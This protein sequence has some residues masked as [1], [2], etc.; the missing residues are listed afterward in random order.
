M[1]YLSKEVDY[2]IQFMHAVPEKGSG[3]LSLRTFSAQT[4]IS[5]LFLQAIARK[6]KRCG[7]VDA[8][9]G[10][11]GGYFTVHKKDS[12]SLAPI[13]EAVQGQSGVV[14][15]M[16]NATCPHTKKCAH[17]D[18]FARLNAELHAF[19]SHKR[20]VDIFPGSYGGS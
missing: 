15:C 5:F 20:L 6:L 19:F 2:A 4:G 8:Q 14:A 16:T 11:H 1:P 13:L 3:V 12:V 17:Q 18:G 7:L 9:K 10:V